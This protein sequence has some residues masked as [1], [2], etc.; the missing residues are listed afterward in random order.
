[1]AD[2]SR[3]GPPEYVVVREIYEHED[4]QEEFELELEK[5]LDANAKIIIIEP[6][7]LGDETAHWISVGNCLHKTSVLTGLGALISGGCWP[8]RGLLFLPL[9]SMSVLCAGVYAISWQFDPCCKYQVEHNKNRIKKIPVHTLTT[10]TPVVLVRRDDK[11]RKLLHN[12][13]S[14]CAG[15]FCAWK[16]YQWYI[17]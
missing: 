1:M 9:G 2:K 14:L 4:A 16:I 15:A 12:T 7:K 8:K 5:A 10:T 6:S 13:V 11:R 3:S 17:E